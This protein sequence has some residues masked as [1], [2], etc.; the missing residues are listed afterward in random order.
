MPKATLTNTRPRPLA[1]RSGEEIRAY[2]TIEVKDYETEVQ[3]SAQLKEYIKRGWVTA[4]IH[5]APAALTPPPP[6]VPAEVS[7][8]EPSGGTA[9][10]KTTF[11]G[12]GK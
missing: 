9:Q 4:S 12:K 1:L 7:S 5:S 10:G 2:G 3:S 11:K 8:G 6:H